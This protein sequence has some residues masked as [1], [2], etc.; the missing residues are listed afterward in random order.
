MHRAFDIHLKVCLEVYK[1]TGRP[2]L[3]DQLPLPATI[4]EFGGRYLWATAAYART[5]GYTVTEL[6]GGMTFWDLTPKDQHMLSHLAIESSNNFGRFGWIDKEWL[7]REGGRI[8]G[9]IRGNVVMIGGYDC[10]FSIID[11]P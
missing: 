10:V 2:V 9:R 8:H 6:E 11:V 5:F 4:C 1:R 3:L 7:H